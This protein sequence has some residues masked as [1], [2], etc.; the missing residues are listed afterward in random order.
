MDSSHIHDNAQILNFSFLYHNK[1]LFIFSLK[2]FFLRALK[3]T[4][5]NIL[6]NDNYQGLAL[7]SFYK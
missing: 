7:F 6:M 5:T 2:N 1:L 4:F 3:L